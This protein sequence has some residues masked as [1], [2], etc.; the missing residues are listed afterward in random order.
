MP[1]APSVFLGE[2]SSKELFRILRVCLKKKNCSGVE[3]KNRKT[4]SI[5]ILTIFQIHD[6]T[7]GR[8]RAR[9]LDGHRLV[10]L[11]DMG[12]VPGQSTFS[13]WAILLG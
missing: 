8:F 11:H 5:L 7:Y 6:V 13:Y 10:G 9:L 4:V 2:R 3:T 12:G 1:G